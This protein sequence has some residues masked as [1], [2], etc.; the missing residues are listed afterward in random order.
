MQGSFEKKVQEKLDELK[1]TP[2]APVWEKIEL[3]IKEEKKR[4]RG[5]LWF[6]FLIILFSGATWWLLGGGEEKGAAVPS[7]TLSPSDKAQSST[8]DAVIA[9]QKKEVPFIHVTPEQNKQSFHTDEIIK[10]DNTRET[11]FRT[12]LIKQK[13]TQR[14][15]QNLQQPTV[16]KKSKTKTSIAQLLIEKVP[17]LAIVQNKSTPGNQTLIEKKDPLQV[18]STMQSQTLLTDSIQVPVKRDTVAAKRKVA[19]LNKKWKFSLSVQAGW[20]SLASLQLSSRPLDYASPNQNTG[21]GFSNN[22]ANPNSSTG[23]T[24][25]VISAGLSRDIS[26]RIRVR[27]GFNYATYR[28]QTKVGTF[29]PLDTM[30]RYQSAMVGVGGY[31]RNGNQ[32]DYT[33]RSHVLEIPVSLDYK[34][35]RALPL[36][37]SAGGAY[38]RLLKTNAITFDRT[39]NIYYENNQ[40]FNRN[41]FALFSSLQ[42]GI[43]NKQGFSLR[44]GPVVQ[45][46]L[47][48]FQ[49]DPGTASQRLLFA[50]V[51]TSFEF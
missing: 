8:H 51:K 49:K 20:S 16:D 2:S 22:P 14:R 32:Q 42:Y 26:R 48:T 3:Q 9:E 18:D 46:Q 45:Y 30:L 40:N 34:L 50:G 43:I 4:R 25:F 1:L 28:S 44:A 35:L 24:A 29:R 36:Y 6:P 23:N 5:L 47:I 27:V 39:S 37:V 38:G 7:A 41:Q 15:N 10:S 33:T 17:N 21:S 31:Y 11:A 13:E 19:S 12:P